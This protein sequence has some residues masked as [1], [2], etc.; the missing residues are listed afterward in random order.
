[1]Y[2]LSHAS[3]AFMII[4]AFMIGWSKP[5]SAGTCESY[6]CKNGD[7]IWCKDSNES[8]HHY[9]KSCPSGQECYDSGQKNKPF[10]KIWCCKP[11]ASFT[12]K[13]GNLHWADSC[14]NKGDWIKDC[15]NNCTIGVGCDPPKAYNCEKECSGCCDGNT[16]AKGNSDSYCGKNGN[17]CKKCGSGYEC[18]SKW[19]Q[20][21]CK[22][23][24]HKS[25]DGKKIVWKDCNENTNDDYKICTYGCNNAS[26][27]KDPPAY[28]CSKKCSGCCDGNSCET[29]SSNSFCGNNGYSCI[30]CSS[31]YTCTGG[32][33]VKDAT[34]YNCSKDCSGCCIGN[35][36]YNGTETTSCGKTGKGCIECLVG[37]FC[38]NQVCEK[39][40]TKYDPCSGKICGS[41]GHVHCVDSDGKTTSQIF[42][43][44][45]G[46][47]DGDVEYYCE[48]NTI[49]KKLKPYKIAC[50]P[51]KLK[52][53][54]VYSEKKDFVKVCQTKCI[55]EANKMPICFQD[56]CKN[57]CVLGATECVSKSK[58]KKCFDD[59]KGCTYWSDTDFSCTSDMVCELGSCV[60]TKPAACNVA[61]AYWS[62]SKAKDGQTV[63]MIIE[64]KGKCDGVKAIFQV[65]ED[66]GSFPGD[67][68][69][70]Q[71]VTLFDASYFEVPWK[72]MWQLDQQGD[73]EYFF[74]VYVGGKMT[75]SSVLLEVVPTYEVELGKL[76]DLYKNLPFE[77][78]T[79][80]DFAGLPP[81]CVDLSIA[82]GQYPDQK[83]PNPE[84]L[85][86]E[87]AIT[88]GLIVGTAGCAIA[89]GLCAYTGVAC[90]VFLIPPV[91]FTCGAILGMDF[92]VG[93]E[94][95][96]VSEAISINKLTGFLAKIQSSAAVQVVSKHV[97]STFATLVGK[98]VGG[99][100]KIYYSL[101]RRKSKSGVVSLSYAQFTDPIFATK[102]GKYILVENIKAGKFYMD[103][104]KIP[105]EY[106]KILSIL[107]EKGN[108]MFET[109]RIAEALKIGQLGKNVRLVFTVKNFAAGSKYMGV[110]IVTVEKIKGQANAYRVVSGSTAY[111]NIKL[112]AEGLITKKTG[113]WKTVQQIISVIVHE[114]AHSEQWG[115]MKTMGMKLVVAPGFKGRHS[116]LE[117]ANE[118]RILQHPGK[119]I[120]QAYMKLIDYKGMLRQANSDRYNGIDMSVGF[121]HWN[122]VYKNADTPD[123]WSLMEFWRI[124][125]L[126]GDKKLA[127]EIEVAFIKKNGAT[128]WGNFVKHAEEFDL[129]AK[130]WATVVHGKEDGQF[131][132]LSK[133]FGMNIIQQPTSKDGMM[134]MVL[135][136]MSSDIYELLKETIKGEICENGDVAI[137]Y[138]DGSKLVLEECQFGCTN[139]KCVG[140]NDMPK[141]LKNDPSIVTGSDAEPTQ[142]TQ[143]QIEGDV[144]T[145]GSC[146][147]SFNHSSNSNL[148]ILCL[149]I[150]FLLFS[151][152]RKRTT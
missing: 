70:P 77:D 146:S 136:M 36:C 82:G 98:G 11:K 23:H 28:V 130:L 143:A 138:K 109:Y 41:D 111:I 94:L 31:G 131:L 96:W 134:V 21:V 43:E 126:T 10:N 63:K 13:N 48:G 150:G 110:N 122:K 127:S 29:G 57:K 102:N 40:P 20:K 141:S 65:V 123:K 132:V 107:Q 7:E 91:A 27:C 97:S 49:M 116:P 79:C 128:A 140:E 76:T 64:T 56:T 5:A 99:A 86:S 103:F 151:I 100:N 152:R 90:S 73:P 26:S 113:T 119:T 62:E 124:A 69:S 14:G 53:D 78:A 95:V 139:A 147:S 84:W 133:K 59:A 121:K 34:P 38:N 115:R 104:G 120:N 42:Q 66:D 135:P 24:D 101:I 89:A 108:F 74:V 80:T 45:N 149:L 32:A 144:V 46:F 3:L 106:K 67:K 117:Y 145:G 68:S 17:K 148:H 61:K 55:H 18:S 105:W 19:C 8:F 142:Q 71:N 129:L 12:C 47:G 37:F 114:I 137:L 50:V 39:E 93:M 88:A 83:I 85:N 6:G 30:K 58:Y 25:C 112:L 54:F 52:C 81:A 1:M 16:C 2:K 60:S 33:C 118:F 9:E 72:A 75:E 15:P 125:Q 92:S 35:K 87:N 22:K 44:C 4:F 51:S